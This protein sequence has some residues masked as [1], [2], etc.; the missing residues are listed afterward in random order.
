ML[1]VPVSHAK[2]TLWQTRPWIYFLG[3]LSGVQ[4]KN[5]MLEYQV[6]VWLSAVLLS[7]VRCM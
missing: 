2:E 1:P 5:W 3:Y 4:M 7:M 6:M